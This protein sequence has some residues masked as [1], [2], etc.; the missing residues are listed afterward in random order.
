MI[1]KFIYI[2]LISLLVKEYGLTKKELENLNNKTLLKIYNEKSVVIIDEK[3]T[4]QNLLKQKHKAHSCCRQ[5]Q[6]L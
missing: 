5:R 3:T 4:K 2:K 1:E 6:S